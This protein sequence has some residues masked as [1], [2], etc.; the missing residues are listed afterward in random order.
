MSLKSVLLNG[1]SSSGK[2]TLAKLL[3]EYIKSGKSAI[4]EVILGEKRKEKINRNSF[5]NVCS[6]CFYYWYKQ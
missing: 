1:A 5:F 2:S 4:C 3:Q 6:T